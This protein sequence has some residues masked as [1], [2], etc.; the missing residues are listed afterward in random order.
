MPT[1][2]VISAMFITGEERILY[3][4]YNREIAKKYFYRY[5][6]KKGWN[7][8]WYETDEDTEIDLDLGEEAEE[9]ACNSVGD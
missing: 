1:T 2:I 4:G 3:V 7:V 9:H 6:F 5:S 8:R